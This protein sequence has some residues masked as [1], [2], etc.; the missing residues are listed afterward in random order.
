MMFL[1][2][3]GVFQGSECI[4]VMHDRLSST[5]VL[6]KF[7]QVLKPLLSPLATPKTVMRH[8]RRLLEALCH[9]QDL[10]LELQTIQLEGAVEARVYINQICVANSKHYEPTV[11]RRL[12]AFTVILLDSSIVKCFI[13]GI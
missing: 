6:T 7:V 9:K 4:C 10:K 12:A 1:E 8:P 2:I 3:I 13:E 5:S 11:A